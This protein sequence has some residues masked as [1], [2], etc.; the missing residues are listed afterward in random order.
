MQFMHFCLDSDI[1]AALI[2][3][4]S[5]SG[6]TRKG[7]PVIIANVASGHRMFTDSVRSESDMA[8]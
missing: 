8:R 7:K 3:R 6:E 5:I 2:S 1:D 4:R